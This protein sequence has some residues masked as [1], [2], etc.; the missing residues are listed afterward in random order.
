MRVRRGIV[1]LS[2]FA[3]LAASI[4]AFRVTVDAWVPCEAELYSAGCL[5]AMDQNPAI[6]GIVGILWVV[7]LALSITSVTVFSLTNSR[8]GTR[9]GVL[10]A[11][12]G[13]VSLLILNPFTDYLVAQAFWS[14]EALW[15]SAPGTGYSTAAALGL[16]SALTLGA[17]I[18]TSPAAPRDRSRIGRSSLS[19]G[20]PGV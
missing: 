19:T 12:A 6:N 7:G 1:A 14:Q 2:G 16:A 5:R 3:L 8:P 13:L 15:D 9:W 4:V 18:S 17:V 10:L 11:V 20:I